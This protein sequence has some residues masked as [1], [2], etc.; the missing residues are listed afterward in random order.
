MGFFDQMK[1]AQDM[2]KNMS[3]EQMQKL[4]EQAKESQKMLKEQVAAHV[5]AEV[6]RLD[7]VSR[8][9]VEKMIRDAKGT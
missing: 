4:M 2:M 7:L 9:E 1:M 5:A 3:P 6:T 8:A